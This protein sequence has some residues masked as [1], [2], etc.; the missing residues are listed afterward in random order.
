MEPKAPPPSSR[1][2]GT[3]AGTPGGARTIPREQDAPRLLI[4]VM[5]LAMLGSVAGVL[6]WVQGTDV[7]EGVIG[8][9]APLAGTGPVLSVDVI[10]D[11]AAAGNV[12]GRD[13]AIWGVP[14]QAVNGDWLFWVG[15]ERDRVIPVVLLG[16]QAARQS[17]RQTEVRA[18]DTVAVYGIVRAVRNAY[19][20]DEPWAMTRDEWRRL[21]Q[22]RVYISALHVEPLRPRR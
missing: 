4:V 7:A 1:A 8:R 13:V 9:P 11:E 20:L 17:E 14:V 12:L 6:Y 15:P 19:Y 16:E 22:A 21:A 10:L 3:P 18:G 5:I 2:P